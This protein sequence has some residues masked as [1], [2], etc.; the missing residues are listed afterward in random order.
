MY[1]VVC[2]S[3]VIVVDVV[4]TIINIVV[5]CIVVCDDVDVINVVRGPVVVM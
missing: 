1:H 3:V 5:T 4:N 2:V